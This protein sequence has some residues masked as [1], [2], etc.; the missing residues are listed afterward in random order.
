MREHRHAVLSRI[1]VERAQRSVVR[2]EARTRRI[3]LDAPEPM[4][5]DQLDRAV[6]DAIVTQIDGREREDELRVAIAEL[7]ELAVLVVDRRRQRPGAHER[8]VHG[9]DDEAR[10]VGIEASNGLEDARLVTFERNLE[11]L[12]VAGELA[13]PP[14]I[15]QAREPNQEAPDERVPGQHVGRPRHVSLRRVLVR[16][17]VDV[18]VR[19]LQRRSPSGSVTTL[20]CSSSESARVK[21]RAGTPGSTRVR[22]AHAAPAALRAGAREL[23]RHRVARAGQRERAAVGAC[24]RG[25]EDTRSPAV[26]T[27]EFLLRSSRSR[28]AIFLSWL[29]GPCCFWRALRLSRWFGARLRSLR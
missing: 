20:P 13:P 28:A 23:H 17:R 6:D 19:D 10:P 12:H 3:Q 1:G 25:G 14:R 4:L 21:R 8:H 15:E 22:A 5:L 24:D 2:V 16:E 7:A 27:T 26:R 9:Q 18:A 11:D 29:K